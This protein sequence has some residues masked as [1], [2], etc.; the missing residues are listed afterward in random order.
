M[1]IV[2][3]FDGSANALTPLLLPSNSSSAEPT[4]SRYSSSTASLYSEINTSSLV[5]Y[6]DKPTHRASSYSPP[7]YYTVSDNGSDAPSALE[8][9]EDYCGNEIV[10]ELDQ[11][12]L[13]ELDPPLRQ[14]MVEIQEQRL[15]LLRQRSLSQAR[16]QADLHGGIAQGMSFTYSR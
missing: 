13:A 16:V 3:D 1:M 11:E 5:E 8:N 6:N 4:P 15:E 10:T 14:V 7:A 2:A 12:A 9:E